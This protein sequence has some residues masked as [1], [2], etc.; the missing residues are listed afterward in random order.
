LTEYRDDI[1]YPVSFDEAGAGAQM[2]VFFDAAKMQ[3]EDTPPEKLKRIMKARFKMDI[4][5]R[6]KEPASPTCWLPY[7]GLTSIR[8]KATAW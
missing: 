5:K 4:I 2:R 1:F 7:I 6:R 3:A 8:M